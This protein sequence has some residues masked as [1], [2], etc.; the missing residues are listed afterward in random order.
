MKIARVVRR[1]AWAF[2][3][4]FG[5]TSASFAIALLLPGDPARMLAG[6]LSGEG[7][8]AAGREYAVGDRVITR[9][10]GSNRRA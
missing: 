8:S 7:I 6:E 10:H 9:R 4:V 2:V 5:V 3:V 1:L